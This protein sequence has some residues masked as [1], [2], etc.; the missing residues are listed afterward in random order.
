FEEP[1]QEDT[2]QQELEPK[3]ADVQHQR[4]DIAASTE[5]QASPSS[6]NDISEDDEETV[7]DWLAEAIDDVESPA[8]I[9][10]DFD[11]E[12]KIQGSDEL[13]NIVESLPEPEPE[14]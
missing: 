12:P 3:E 7:E 4:E 10:S 11:F 6:L 5:D 9:D 8:N 13:E 2:E 14:P 1:T